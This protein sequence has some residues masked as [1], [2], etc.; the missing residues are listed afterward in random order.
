MSLA[1]SAAD[2]K[3]RSTVDAPGERNQSRK[4]LKQFRI[5]KFQGS[6]ISPE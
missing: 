5:D 2:L 1:I 4:V 3:C 6:K